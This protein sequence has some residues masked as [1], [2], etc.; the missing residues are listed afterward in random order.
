MIPFISA[1]LPIL[2]VIRELILD[3][4]EAGKMVSHGAAEVRLFEVLEDETSINCELP[5]PKSR[6]RN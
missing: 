1:A 3:L 2:S 6:D 5:W 4:R